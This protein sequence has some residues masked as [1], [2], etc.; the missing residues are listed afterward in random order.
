MKQFFMQYESDRIVCGSNKHEWGC[1]ASSLATAKGYIR[2]CRKEKAAEN[3]RNFRIFDSWADVD[4][5]TNYVPC[6]Y[7]I[8]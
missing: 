4:P 7:S 8:A 2:R 3:P 6:V 1:R 5:S